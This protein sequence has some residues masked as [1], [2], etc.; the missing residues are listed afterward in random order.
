MSI[1]LVDEFITCIKHFEA[2]DTES[3]FEEAIQD[4]SREALL[5]TIGLEENESSF[6]SH[7]RELASAGGRVKSK[8]TG[9]GGCFTPGQKAVA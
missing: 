6:G 3:F 1:V 9:G 7:Q 4:N 8:A 5:D 2:T